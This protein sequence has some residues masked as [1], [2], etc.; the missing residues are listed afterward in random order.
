MTYPGKDGVV[1]TVKVK[2]PSNTLVRPVGKICVME[3]YTPQKFYFHEGGEC[4]DK[5]VSSYTLL[6]IG[7]SLFSVNR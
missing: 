7:Q 1:R 2:T 5:T 3:K 6:A 4:F